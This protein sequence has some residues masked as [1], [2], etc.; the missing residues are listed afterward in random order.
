MIWK[1]K[2]LAV[3]LVDGEM[4]DEEA[5]EWLAELIQHVE[6]KQ[7]EAVVFDATS[8]EVLDTHLSGLVCD[9]AVTVQIMGAKAVLCGLSPEISATITQAEFDQQF[10]TAGV[11]TAR[12]L[13]GAMELLGLELRRK[14]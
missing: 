5:E 1:I 10:S 14:Q 7:P 11:L 12:D 6:R 8:V 9:G 4:T 2:G 3:T 13:E